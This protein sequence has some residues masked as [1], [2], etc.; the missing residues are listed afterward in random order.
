MELLDLYDDNGKRTG[1]TI[2]RGTKFDKGNIMLS[3]IFIKN[4]EGKFL[5]QKTSKEK[6]AIYSSTGGHVIHNEDGLITIV[7]EVNEELGIDVD[8]NEIKIIGL[9]KHPERPCL[10]NLYLL[11]KNID[12]N[13][14]KLQ[15]EEVELVEWLSQ[16]E[17]LN[18]ISDNKFLSSHGY[19]FKEYIASLVIERKKLYR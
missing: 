4:S 5:I 15:S 3:I 9:K 2:E 11:E 7:R 13:C 6:G 1:Q 8:S 19:L 16:D 17:I 12:I 10:I 18:L 14:L